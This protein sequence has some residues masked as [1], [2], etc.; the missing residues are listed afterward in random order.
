[1][2]RLE[3]STWFGREDARLARSFFLIA[4][5]LRTTLEIT[6]GHGYINR[7]NDTM[8]LNDLGQTV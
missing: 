4:A 5:F 6:D 7:S 2:M 1:M 3:Y 8:E